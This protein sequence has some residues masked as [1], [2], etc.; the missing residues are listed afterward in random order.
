[1]NTFT[2][3]LVRSGPNYNQNLG[4]VGY[5]GMCGSSPQVDIAINC[6]QKQFNRH[7]RNLRYGSSIDESKRA[8]AISFLKQLIGK[9]IFNNMPALVAETAKETGPLHLKLLVAAKELAQLPFELAIPPVKLY[10]PGNDEFEA[11]KNRPIVITRATRQNSNVHYQW[12]FKPRI[13]FA[14]AQPPDVAPVPWEK[15]L[16]ALEEAVAMFALPKKNVVE[17][18]KDFA[19]LITV[20][21]KVTLVELEERIKNEKIQVDKGNPF[22]HVHIL[23]HGCKI[24]NE[25]D[26]AYE[27]KLVLHAPGNK[28]KRKLV[29]SQELAKA[30]LGS[31][32]NAAK[33]PAVVSLMTCDSANVGSVIAES[34]SLAHELHEIGVPC[35][36]ASQFPLT[37]EGSVILVKS[38]YNSLLNGADPRHALYEAREALDNP[39][40]HDWASLVAYTRFP[41]DIEEQLTA[42]KLS[43][44]FA[45]MR[46]MSTWADH[47]AKNVGDDVKRSIYD[48]IST[49]LK[50]FTDSDNPNE[51]TKGYESLLLKPELQA[52]HLALIGSA[53]KRK[54]EHCYRLMD[55]PGADKHTLFFQSDQ[56]LKES[57]LFYK[58]G[59]DAC[60]WGHWPAMQYLSLKAAIDGTLNGDEELWRYILFTTQI[61]DEKSRKRTIND[62]TPRY[63]LQE[64]WAFGTLA[65]LYLLEPLLA[66]SAQQT[67][68]AVE[69]LKNANSYIDKLRDADN[70]EIIDSVT[71]QLQRYINWWPNL[72][73][74]KFP[75]ILKDRAASMLANM[76]LSPLL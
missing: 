9:Q 25:D 32:G 54:A 7:T 64:L 70:E 11:C 27:F 51:F 40:R 2:V 10:K 15:H 45:K 36:F 21:P 31:T 61:A 34:G 22:T 69:S 63:N 65:E 76:F 58:A 26:D 23:A 19:P 29:S 55:L 16:K 41:Q 48:D 73:P 1:M 46:V 66:G 17:A 62:P 37:E 12:P 49:R 44:M 13:L 24:E 74:N 8:E 35:V 5:I 14:W 3:E 67:S 43:L 6:T 20:L 56:A 39:L 53:Y 57:K 30:V 52:E 33:A 18:E 71:R 42:N 28:S 59:F 72:N 4:S 75:M 38:L 68:L 47:V 50:E 60:I